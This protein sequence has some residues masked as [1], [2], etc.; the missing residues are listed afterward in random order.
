M[1]VTMQQVGTVRKNGALSF[2][3]AVFGTLWI[4]NTLFTVI[5]VVSFG[6][7]LLLAETFPT[8]TDATEQLIVSSSVHVGTA[9]STL[10]VAGL[11]HVGISFIEGAAHKLGLFSWVGAVFALAYGFDVWTTANGILVFLEFRGINADEYTVVVWG[12]AL[13]I[14]FVAEKGIV[15]ALIKLGVFR[16]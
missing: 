11:L 7:W 12:G 13:I 2:V 8:P 16:K 6:E 5:Q 1:A 9:L 4:L 15:E 14:A 3:L 10:W